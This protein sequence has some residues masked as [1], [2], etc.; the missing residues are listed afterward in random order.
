M[1]KAFIQQMLEEAG[2]RLD[3]TDVTLARELWNMIPSEKLQ[4]FSDV[5]IGHCAEHCRPLL[6]HGQLVV[7]L[8]DDLGEVRGA[9]G[10]R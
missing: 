2:I 3:L 1:D 6:P 8:I 9:S 10:D 7:L 4:A 5:I